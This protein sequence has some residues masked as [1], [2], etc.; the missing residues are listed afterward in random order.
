MEARRLRR[1]KFLVGVP[2]AIAGST[3]ACGRKPGGWRFFTEE[4]GRLVTAICDQIIPPD[5]DPGG[6][7]AGVPVFID[8][9]LT[10]FHK[11]HQK[12]YRAG[13]GAVEQASRARFAKSFLELDG[14]DQLAVL[15]FI[16][17]DSATKAFFGLIVGHAMQGFYGSPRHGGNRN[18]ASWRMLGLP[19]PPVRGRQI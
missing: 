11:P 2:A 4:E 17:K 19:Y 18:A 13:L 3:V 16:E 15:E 1:R 12:A 7:A 6:S 8:R 5:R 14:D 9:Q 10:R